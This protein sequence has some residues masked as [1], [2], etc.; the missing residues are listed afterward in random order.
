MVVVAFSNINDSM[1]SMAVTC[2]SIVIG[3]NEVILKEKLLKI[4]NLKILNWKH[5]L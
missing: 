3:K 2:G 1:I 4:K 5:T